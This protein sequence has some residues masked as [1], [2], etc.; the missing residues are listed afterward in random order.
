MDTLRRVG[1]MFARLV[2][3]AVLIVSGWMFIINLVEVS[4]EGWILVW[5]LLSGLAGVAG[6]ALYLLSIDG[7]DRYRTRGR[8]SLGWVA[9]LL[10]ML[11]PTSLS[12]FLLPTLAVLIP[13]LFIADSAGGEPVTSS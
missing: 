2:A 8:R 5:I 3:L 11:L 6:G 13:T 7:P 4:Y 1:W 12:F 9:M 10:A